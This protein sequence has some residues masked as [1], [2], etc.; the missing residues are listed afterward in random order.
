VISLDDSVLSKLGVILRAGHGTVDV[1]SLYRDIAD[2]FESIDQFLLAID[3]L[4][5]L[6]RIEI[7]FPT[8][9]LTYVE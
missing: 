8:R 6:G 5:V 1:V 3:T 9:I 2:S 7:D 4:Y